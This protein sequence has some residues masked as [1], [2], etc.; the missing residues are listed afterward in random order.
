MAVDSG[1]I[2]GDLSGTDYG[3]NHERFL[4]EGTYDYTL[5][6]KDSGGKLAFKVEVREYPELGESGNP[7]WITIEEKS[8]IRGGSTLNGS[9]R[10]S[11][12]LET[13]AEVRFN[14]N[15]EFLSHKVGYELTF[16]KRA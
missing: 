3:D 11:S 5:K 14:F 6:A 8:K 10:A 13:G 2:T 9:F 1:K 4:E 16:E 12:S 7:R 15:R